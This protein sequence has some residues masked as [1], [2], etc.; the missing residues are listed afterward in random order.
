MPILIEH[1]VG[2]NQVRQNRLVE[3]VANLQS[4]IV[5]AIQHFFQLEGNIAEGRVSFGDVS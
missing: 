1:E 3:V 5:P 2:H 4:G